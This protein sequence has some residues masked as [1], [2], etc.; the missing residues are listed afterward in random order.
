MIEDA[1]NLDL[2]RVLRAFGAVN[3]KGELAM[4]TLGALLEQKRVDVAFTTIWMKNDVLRL[5]DPAPA[6]EKELIKDPSKDPAADD[7]NPENFIGEY[8]TPM[9]KKD[10][11]PLICVYLNRID[12][13]SKGNPGARCFTICWTFIHECMH[14]LFDHK[15]REKW[16]PL[17]SYLEEPTCECGAIIIAQELDRLYPGFGDYVLKEV[18]SKKDRY[19]LGADLYRYWPSHQE[20]K[21]NAV[22]AYNE[23]C[24][25]IVFK[26]DGCAVDGWKGRMPHTDAIPEMKE[27]YHIALRSGSN[28][29]EKLLCASPFC[30]L[31]C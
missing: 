30:T 13:N 7:L 28:Q 9:K 12:Y 19:G 23:A 8:F 5:F 21:D 31:P 14:A 6:V 2:S 18:D 17:D 25:G 27:I 16:H 1:K 22:D 29:T 26:A 10:E 24:D 15:P 20:Q 3:K 11:F 4:P